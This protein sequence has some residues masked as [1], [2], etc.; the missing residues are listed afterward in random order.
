MAGLVVDAMKTKGTRFLTQCVPTVIAREADQR[1]RV[2]YTDSTT[3][4][5]HTEI[6]DT[7]LTAMGRSTSIFISFIGYHCRSRYNFNFYTEIHYVS[8]RLHYNANG[9]LVATVGLLS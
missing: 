6:Y 9:W 2:T 3:G 4:M 8:C 5:Q 7:V 1:L